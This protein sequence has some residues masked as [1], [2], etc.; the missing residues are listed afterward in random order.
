MRGDPRTIDDQGACDSEDDDENWMP[1]PSD[2]DPG[3]PIMLLVFRPTSNQFY[4]SVYVIQW[5]SH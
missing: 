2:A 4:C 3:R 5:P 1:A